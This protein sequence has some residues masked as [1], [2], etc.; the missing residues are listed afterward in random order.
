M[1]GVAISKE[2]SLFLVPLSAVLCNHKYLIWFETNSG[3]NSHVFRRTVGSVNDDFRVIRKVSEKLGLVS[4]YVNGR[5]TT[6]KRDQAER[7][8]VFRHPRHDLVFLKIRT[9]C[10]V[11]DEVS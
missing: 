7:E 5:Q 1:T 4:T 2:R 9:T 11:H 3:I 6:A 8:V 10:D